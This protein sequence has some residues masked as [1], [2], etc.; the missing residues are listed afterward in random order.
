MAELRA[1]SEMEEEEERQIR[2]QEEALAKTFSSNRAALAELRGTDRV[3]SK[4]P[5][6]N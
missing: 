2:A 6:K 4:N 1:Q 3:V 5:D